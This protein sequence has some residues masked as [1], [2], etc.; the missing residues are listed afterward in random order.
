MAIVAIVA[1]VV[2]VVCWERSYN[3]RFKGINSMSSTSIRIK[4]NVYSLL[5]TNSKGFETIS[6][7]I[8]RS[9]AAL[10]T[11]EAIDMIKRNVEF[12]I[13]RLDEG[14][15]KECNLLVHYSPSS[16]E[17]A[18]TLI[19]GLFVNFDIEYEI[20]SNV[21]TFKVERKN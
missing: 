21:F 17:Y 20:R 16:L 15:P 6:D 13:N 9:V 7:T 10:E 8:E 1:I 14:Y 18:V 12:A 2:V 4:D 3:Y 19:Q 5:E 11:L